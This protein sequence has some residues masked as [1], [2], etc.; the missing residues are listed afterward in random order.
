[1]DMSNVDEMYMLFADRLEAVDNAAPAAPLHVK[2]GKVRAG[3]KGAWALGM[4]HVQHGKVRAGG[5]GPGC[6][7]CCTSSSARWGQG[8]RGP[9]AGDAARPARQGAA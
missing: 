6:C 1:M 9:G 2:H 7:G 5:K 3:G 4:L 8:G